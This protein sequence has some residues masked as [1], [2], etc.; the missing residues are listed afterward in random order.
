MSQMTARRR[1]GLTDAALSFRRVFIGVRG[2]I[3]SADFDNS[4][5]NVVTTSDARAEDIRKLR[6]LAKHGWENWRVAIS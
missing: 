6:A 2:V 4:E 3:V 1:S 5:I